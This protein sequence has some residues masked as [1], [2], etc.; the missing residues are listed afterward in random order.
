MKLPPVNSNAS[1][2]TWSLRDH[3]I[4]L[5][6]YISTT[7]VLRATKLGRMVTYLNELL[8]LMSHY[9]FSCGLTRSCDKLKPL[10]LHFQSPYDHQA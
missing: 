2:I 3:V 4:N 8:L 7:T 6:Y 1:L 10:Y 9:L 5:S